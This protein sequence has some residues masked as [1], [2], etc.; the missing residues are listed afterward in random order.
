MTDR[1]YLRAAMGVAHDS[2]RGQVEA[3]HFVAGTWHRVAVALAD[4]RAAPDGARD[5]QLL[6]GTRFCVVTVQD[7][8]AFGFDDP[9]GYCGWLQEAALGADHPV[10]H[11][12]AT[13]ATHAYPAA[14]MKTPEVMALSLGAQLQVIGEQ[15]KFLQTP[16]GFVPASHLQPLSEPLS[17]PVA[18]ARSLLGTPYLWGGNS[19]GGIDCSGLVQIARR[20]CGLQSPAD[21]DFQ[22]VMPG[23]DIAH[24]ELRTGDLIFWKGH[25]AMVSGAGTILHANATHMAVVEEDL[26]AAIARIAPSDGPVVRRLRA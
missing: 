7:R 1:R 15:G 24:E 25:V 9:E 12:V 19:R 13:P 22:Q 8:W 10:S 4:L 26:E 2:L 11:F 14:D 3:E 18:A 20:V 16:Q 17:D 23:Q 5:R 6:L 21:S